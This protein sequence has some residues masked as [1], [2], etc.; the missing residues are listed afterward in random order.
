M[1]NNLFASLAWM[2]LASLKPREPSRC[3]YCPTRPD[4]HWAKWGS[5]RRWAPGRKEKI[6]VQCYHCPFAGRWF[7]LLPEGL[8]PYRYRTTA[9]T[10]KTLDAL[11]VQEIPVSRWSRLK[12]I[13]RTTLRRVK[14]SFERAVGLLRLPGHE[15]RLSPAEFLRT[16]A[17][18]GV[19][20]VQDLFTGWKELEPKHSIVGLY[21]R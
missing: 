20:A 11:V 9:W 1:N 19:Q 21:A 18:R 7:S 15:G 3:P 17:R 2:A 13:A 4:P 12:K 5:Y 10:L 16:L 14:A 6:R 8:L